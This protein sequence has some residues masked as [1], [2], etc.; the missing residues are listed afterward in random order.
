M[1]QLNQY[2]NLLTKTTPLTTEEQLFITKIEQLIK[3]AY[4]YREEITSA[5][6]NYL[7]N[8]YEQIMTEILV[9]P[10]QS[11]T[12]NMQEALERNSSLINNKAETRQ[13]KETQSL[14]L[15]KNNNQISYGFT[16]A[17]IIIFLVSLLGIITSVFLLT[18]T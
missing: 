5:M 13:N 1:T 11:R 15:K 14:A 4:F 8:S 9:T 16:N 17:S 6:V 12:S 18:L 3:N 10:E 2:K 7:L